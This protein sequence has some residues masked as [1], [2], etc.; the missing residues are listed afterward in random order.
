MQYEEFHG[1][2][3]P[4]SEGEVQ[5]IDITQ[6]KLSPLPSW[7]QCS[8]GRCVMYAPETQPQPQPQPQA[9]PQQLHRQ[10]GPSQPS[11]TVVSLGKSWCG[12]STKQQQAI[13]KAANAN[14]SYTTDV[15]SSYPPATAFPT[16]YAVRGSVVKLLKTG[17]T[18]DIDGLLQSARDLLK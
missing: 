15:P 14:V 7:Q 17:F 16:H 12:Y 11:V 6:L 18:T 5:H 10:Q 3:V 8:T 2:H 4:S 13:A 1:V 9:Q